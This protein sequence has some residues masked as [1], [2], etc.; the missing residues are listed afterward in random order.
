MKRA[1]LYIVILGIVCIG[2]GVAGGIAI[3][4]RYTA[5]NLPRIV[6]GQLFRH[7]ERSCWQKPG[8]PQ[9]GMQGFHQRGMPGLPSRK[10]QEAG[11][12]STCKRI[13]QGLDLSSEQE[14][15][16]QVILEESKQEIKQARD[17]FKEQLVQVRG[18]SHTQIL[19]LLDPEQREKFEELTARTKERK[20]RGDRRG[21]R[22]PH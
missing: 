1:T 7:A 4:K 2:L 19:E 17:G 9:G 8:F 6:R 15:K 21:P 10:G 16:V 11:L 18:K 22:R 12:T 13:G 14:E 5:R 3:E 20:E